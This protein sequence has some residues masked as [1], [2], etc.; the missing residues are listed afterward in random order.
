MW[1]PLIFCIHYEKKECFATS[2]VT[3]FW[4]VEDTCNSLYLYVVS[5]N[6][7]V[8]WVAKFQ[9]T[10]YALQFIITESKQ[11]T[12][13]YYATPLQLYTPWCHVDV[14]NC[15]PCIKIWHVTLWNFLDKLFSFWNIDLHRSLWLLTMVWNYEMWH[16]RNCHMA[17]F[18]VFWKKK[19][20]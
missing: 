16:N 11:V 13:N 2:L 5:V 12:F 20:N 10:I 14:I 8:A 4:V 18:V 17:Y 3:H 19:S 7:Q 9:L 6:G 1:H 15:H